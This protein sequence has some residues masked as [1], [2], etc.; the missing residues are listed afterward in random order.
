M[1]LFLDLLA[2]HPSSLN[3]W[4][5]SLEMFTPMKKVGVLFDSELNFEKQVNAVVKSIVC[6]T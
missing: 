3:T 5:P 4:G 2:L 6:I 1:L